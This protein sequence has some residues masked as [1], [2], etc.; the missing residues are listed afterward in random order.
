MVFQFE[1]SCNK[2]YLL[3][4]HSIAELVNSTISDRLMQLC[5]L[6]QH[7]R[8]D[9]PSTSTITFE[10]SNDLGPSIDAY[11]AMGM[12]CDVK[13]D[14]NTSI[15]ITHHILTMY[16]YSL[17]TALGKYAPML[18]R[19]HPYDINSNMIYFKIMREALSQT[20]DQ[21]HSHPVHNGSGLSDTLST[22]IQTW[23]DANV[24]VI[25]ENDITKRLADEVLLIAKGSSSFCLNSFTG[26][27]GDIF[28]HSGERKHKVTFHDWLMLL[29]API[30]I[31]CVGATPSH[32][33]FQ[34]DMNLYRL[35]CVRCNA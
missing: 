12:T 24:D 3:F 2:T 28:F 15:L 33:H 32:Q 19:N 5:Q 29:L 8:Q 1:E 10:V 18:R 7:H 35:S 20:L 21:Y 30:N 4:Q 14:D 23:F 16:K 34:G 11:V 26:I 13:E 17:R 25:N 27:I 31:D 6:I 9:Y 22:N